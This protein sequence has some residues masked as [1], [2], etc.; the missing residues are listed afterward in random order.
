MIPPGFR[1]RFRE[2]KGPS[3]GSA[4]ICDFNFAKPRCR[5]YVTKYDEAVFQ[6]DLSV[7][8]K[9]VSF[10]AP[11]PDCQR[12]KLCNNRKWYLSKDFTIYELC[13]EEAIKGT[14]LAKELPCE[15]VPWEA[16]C[17]LYSPRMRTLWRQACEETDLDGFSATA[18]KRLEVF[19]Y[20]TMR[21]QYILSQQQIRM[22]Q[23]NALFMTSLIN[24]GTDGLAAITGSGE[25]SGP[26]S[27]G[28]SIMGWGYMA[29]AGAESAMQFHQAWTSMS[30]SP[31]V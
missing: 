9:F 11:L 19:A 26:Y 7:S 17:H 20:K 15:I 6:D 2:I 18:R 14:S 27:Y 3:D 5:T 13:Y 28:N 1:S 22:S 30:S 23:Q 8:S 21:E 31:G 29:L 4:Y 24:Q 12:S 10:Y 16:M 25:A